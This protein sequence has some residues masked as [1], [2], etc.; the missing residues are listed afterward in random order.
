MGK[1]VF[2]HVHALQALLKTGHLN[3]RL[4]KTKMLQRTSYSK[5]GGEGRAVNPKSGLYLKGGVNT[6]AGSSSLRVP[7][8]IN[9][10]KMVAASHVG[11]LRT[12]TAA[13]I[14]S[15]DM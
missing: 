7:E 2:L 5:G 1:L 8:C 13:S 6:M 12:I 14:P 3:F 10:L 4:N 11:F 15:E 9:E